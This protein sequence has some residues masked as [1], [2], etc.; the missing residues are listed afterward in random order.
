MEE[1]EIF[2]VLAGAGSLTFQDG[3]S[4]ELRPGAVVRLVKGD[5]TSWT[6]TQR[7]RKLYVAT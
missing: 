6:I 3:S 1:D 2:V 4:L 5:R 7:L